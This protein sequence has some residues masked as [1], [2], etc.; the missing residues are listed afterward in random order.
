MRLSLLLVGCWLSFIFSSLAPSSYGADISQKGEYR[1]KAAF[2]YNFAKF[3]EWPS[4]AFSDHQAPH[5][6][7]IVG[8]DPFGPEIDQLTTKPI[9]N[10]QLTIKRLQPTDQLLGC[11]LLYV[12]RTEL[13]QATHILGTLQKT[14]VLTICDSDGCAESGFMLN[15]R[16]VE[17]RVTLDLNLEAVEQTPLKLSSQL[18]KLTRV[19]KG[20]P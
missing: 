9:H 11:H 13:G 1:L 14:P 20:Q 5:T 19:V 8:E 12:S 10:R 6:I 7:C 2:L 15:M 16:M 17:N 3:T 4:T 18:I